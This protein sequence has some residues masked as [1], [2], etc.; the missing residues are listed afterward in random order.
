VE[1][2]V[3]LDD[4]SDLLSTGGVTTTIYKGFMPEQPNDAF[5]LTETAGLGP[6]HAMSTGPG[7]AKLEVAGLQVIRRSQSY[8]TARSGMQSVMDLLDG[9]TERTINATRY[10]YVSAQQVPFSL[11]RDDAERTMLSVNFLAW[12][13]LSTG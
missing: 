13:D 5:I 2:D 11:G 4:I 10:S 3:L 1:R 6:I 8:S 7:Q 9:L 12:K